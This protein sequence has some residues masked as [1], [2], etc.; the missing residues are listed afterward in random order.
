MV[1]QGLKHFVSHTDYTLEDNHIRTHSQCDEVPEEGR[2]MSLQLKKTVPSTRVGW[3]S[4]L[5]GRDR[6]AD[7]QTDRQTVKHEAVVRP[8]RGLWLHLRALEHP[9]RVMD[10]GNLSGC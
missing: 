9:P 5:P 2:V 4:G 1:R 6:Y 8:P 7:R 10:S 3:E